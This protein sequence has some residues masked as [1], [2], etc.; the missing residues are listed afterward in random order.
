MCK[1]EVLWNCF[2]PVFNLYEPTAVMC[3]NRAG[4]VFVVFL[5]RVHS[6]LR[7]RFLVCFGYQLSDIRGFFYLFVC[8]A[9]F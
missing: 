9:L 2:I 7:V 4:G 1:N 8:F 6:L 5:L 3:I